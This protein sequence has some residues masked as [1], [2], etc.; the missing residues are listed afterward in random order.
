M[1]RGLSN[2]QRDILLF[3][4][5]YIADHTYPPTIR[6]ICEGC[7]I[8]ST[9]VVDYNLKRLEELE[10][11]KRDS[12]VSR[13]IQVLRPI[14]N[15]TVNGR[16]MVPL[17]GR[18]AAGRPIPVPGEGNTFEDAHEYIELARGLVKPPRDKR[19]YALRVE[20]D[21]MIG[22]LISDGDIVIIAGQETADNGDMIA[23]W[24]DRGHGDGETTLKRIYRQGNQVMLKPSN[25][26][27]EE[28]LFP[29]SQVQVMGRVFMVIR[30][31][32]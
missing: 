4:E 23:A 2:R 18:I 1:A 20:G 14:G 10:Y 5:E 15:L 24:V 11:I 7:S 12:E 16:L 32:A 9:S 17:V 27:M 22:D 3:I 21:S 30:T 28:M 19:L 6:D 13:G 26:L 31:C 25:P 8:S 29:A